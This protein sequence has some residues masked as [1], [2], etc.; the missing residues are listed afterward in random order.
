MLGRED[1][2]LVLQ[3]PS[4]ETKDFFTRQTNRRLHANSELGAKKPK[5]RIW[6]RS[7]QYINE[8]NGF[9][10]GNSF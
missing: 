3:H 8:A 2:L 1:L 9:A 7:R 4:L 6:F 5:I 10:S